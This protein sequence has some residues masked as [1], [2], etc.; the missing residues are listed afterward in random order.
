M[1]LNVRSDFFLLW[2]SETSNGNVDI[3][4]ILHK[5]FVLMQ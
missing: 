4:N 1:L 3:V 2:Y 5:M